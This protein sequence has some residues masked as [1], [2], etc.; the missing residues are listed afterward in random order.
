[1]FKISYMNNRKTK[2]IPR[3][4]AGIAGIGRNCQWD[5]HTG[6]DCWCQKPLLERY[7]KITQIKTINKCD[8]MSKQEFELWPY[9]KYTVIAYRDWPYQFS[10]KHLIFWLLVSSDPT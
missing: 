10:F 2:L 1:M 3:V 9:N 4:I 5:F 8:D 7:T 6:T